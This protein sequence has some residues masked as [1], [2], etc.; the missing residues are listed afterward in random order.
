MSEDLTGAVRYDRLMKEVLTDFQFIEEG[1]RLYLGSCYRIIR[2]KLAG[3][4]PYKF[5]Y[6]DNESHALG[7][8]IA[9][10]A[11]F[12]DD[13]ALVTELKDL[14]QYRNGVAHR[15]YFLSTQELGDRAL[16]ERLA[17]N[18]AEVEE[19]TKLCLGHL[20]KRIADLIALEEKMKIAEGALVRATVMSAAQKALEDAKARRE[21]P[22]PD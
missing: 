15:G 20:A 10:F 11:R 19:R 8:L 3:A 18:L 21:G 14:V 2:H 6:E 16:L 12:C 5:E 4:L 13:D 7:K 9:Q 17:G 1:L 22:M